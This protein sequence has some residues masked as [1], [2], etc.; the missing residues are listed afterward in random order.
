MLPYFYEIRN[1][2]NIQISY[3]GEPHNTIKRGYS[4]ASIKRT[5][6]LLYENKLNL[7]FK[8]TLTYDM[9]K[10]LPKI[11]KS[12]EHLQNEFP[13]ININYSPTLDTTQ[14]DINNDYYIDWINSLIQISKYELNRLKSGNNYIWSWFHSYDDKSFCGID[15]RLMLNADG[16]IYICHGCPYSKNNGDFIINNTKNIQSLY[17]IFYH[18]KNCNNKLKRTCELCSASICNNCHITFCNSKYWKNT[19]IDDFDKNKLRCKFFKAFGLIKHAL[20]FAIL[21]K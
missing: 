9:I 21:H 10:N 5:I 8:A 15:N 12:Y 18:N 17:D 6:Q 16:N 14:C 19:W 2:F 11:W 7:K 13:D 1:R 20:E 4:Y 3:D